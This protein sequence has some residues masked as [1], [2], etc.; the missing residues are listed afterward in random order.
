[1]YIDLLRSDL[2]FGGFRC[3]YSFCHWPTRSAE[4]REYLKKSTESF[5]GSPN[6]RLAFDKF[7]CSCSEP[8]SKENKEGRCLLIDD[9][10]ENQ[11]H[12]KCS[13][14]KLCKINTNGKEKTFD[15]KCPI[16]TT[17]TNSVNCKQI[18]HID[19]CQPGYLPNPEMRR[20]YR[21]K[22]I[23][24][25]SSLNLTF[26]IRFELSAGNNSAILLENYFDL[27]H[28]VNLDRVPKNLIKEFVDYK[29]STLI[30]T[31]DRV[32]DKAI[33]KTKLEQILVSA[34]K[35]QMSNHMH[36]GCHYIVAKL[37]FDHETFSLLRLDE[38]LVDVNLM[39]T[40][41]TYTTGELFRSAFKF[42]LGF[43]YFNSNYIK[44][45]GVGNVIPESIF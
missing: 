36:R 20:D 37:D 21:Q 41:S 40:C 25:V 30:Y 35:S 29:D 3:A 16:E 22:C 14:D 45:R 2:G 12:G 11:N 24:G 32:M 17:E 10:S 23:K 19:H 44:F 39:I 1:M 15:C 33:V 9:C 31:M 7:K 43:N 27:E 18:E 5:C 26:Q 13:K 4:E 28:E 34:F 8:F 6:C 42:Q 38:T